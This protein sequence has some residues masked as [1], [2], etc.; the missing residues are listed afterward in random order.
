MNFA[1]LWFA[2]LCTHCFLVGP[3]RSDPI[4]KKQVTLGWAA[5]RRSIICH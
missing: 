2:A 3:A 1:R 4:E 5:R